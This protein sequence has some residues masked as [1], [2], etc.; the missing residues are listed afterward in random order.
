[1]II[2]GLN[3]GHDSS[4]TILVNNKVKASC[5]QERYNKI[6]HTNDF[7][8]E[9]IRD[10]LKISKINF[11]DIDII[12]VGFLPIKYIKELYLKT[13]VEDENRIKF[14]IDD[15]ERI[16]KVYNIENLIRSKLRF[17]KKN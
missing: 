13:A 9:A 14:L 10:C 7:P 3:L 4:A 11:K 5:E 1:M 2:L 6:K 15:I 17:K 12:S 8:V 16:K